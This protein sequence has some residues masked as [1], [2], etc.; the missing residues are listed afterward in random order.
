M[1]TSSP[2]S[3][4]T[5]EATTSDAEFETINLES[6][7]VETAGKTAMS[8]RISIQ[9]I[10]ED[11][12]VDKRTLNIFYLAISVAST[13]ERVMESVKNILKDG[14]DDPA[15]QEIEELLD[16]FESPGSMDRDTTKPSINNVAT[17][18]R[19]RCARAI[20]RNTLAVLTVKEKIFIDLDSEIS[21][22]MV[23]VYQCFL[24]TKWALGLYLP[25][26]LKLIATMYAVDWWATTVKPMRVASRTLKG[27]SLN[28]IINAYS[29][30]F[31]DDFTNTPLVE[32]R[33]V[34]SYKIGTTRFSTVETFDE[35]IVDICT[36]F[37][38]KHKDKV[39]ALEKNI[40][41]ETVNSIS[42]SKDPLEVTMSGFT[43]ISKSDEVLFQKAIASYINKSEADFNATITKMTFAWM[44]LFL[45]AWP[46][47]W[48]ELASR[49]MLLRRC[50]LTWEA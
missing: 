7:A 1:S 48:G 38:L 8:Y 4:T 5:A 17:S 19:D 25:A 13:K 46:P 26:E 42:Y 18:Y 28:I 45:I 3:K 41:L 37:L 43:G 30:T 40:D 36:K 31:I 11:N 49:V 29:D 20:L 12:S 47:T 34:E 15:Y 35:A 21:F 14:M 16:D 32:N 23:D 6:F 2:F 39:V 22:N 9:K 10:F 27:V 24:L 44:A 50:P 33:D